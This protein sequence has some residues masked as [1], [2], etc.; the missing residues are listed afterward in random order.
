MADDA[1]AQGHDS[2]A[3]L[4]IL[5]CPTGSGIPHKA[6]IRLACTFLLSLSCERNAGFAPYCCALHCHGVRHSER[7]NEHMQ[8]AFCWQA[9]RAC[10]WRASASARRC[11]MP[12]CSRQ[13]LLVRLGLAPLGSPCASTTIRRAPCSLLKNLQAGAGHFTR[14]P[15]WPA[16]CPREPRCSLQQRR[17]PLSLGFGALSNAPMP[18]SH[19]LP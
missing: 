7:L 17:T 5:G 9:L 11:S 8:R 18:L 2:S 10:H 4:S 6:L 12:M 14:L 3:D 19:V 13:C 15:T 1:L 16:L